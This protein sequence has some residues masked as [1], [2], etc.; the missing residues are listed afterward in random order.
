MVNNKKADVISPYIQ[1][2][3]LPYFHVHIILLAT[4]AHSVRLY[5]N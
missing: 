3:I 5:Y 2:S 4:E 1:F